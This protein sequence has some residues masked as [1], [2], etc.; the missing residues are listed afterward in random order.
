MAKFAKLQ[1]VTLNVRG[2]RNSKKRKCIFKWLND[3]GY[4][5]VCVQE[6]FI[7]SEIINIINNDWNGLSYHC[8]SDSAHSRGVSIFIKN[9]L[10]ITVNDV[11]TCKDARRLLINIKYKNQGYTIVCTKP[12]TS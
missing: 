4:D 1:L 11:H 2:I 9:G 6:S 10:D 7:T 12:A 8:I 3:K 5:I